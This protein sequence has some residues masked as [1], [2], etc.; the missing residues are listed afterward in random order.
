MK[1]VI[2]EPNS[3]ILKSF[4]SDKHEIRCFEEELDRDLLKRFYSDGK[5]WAFAAQM[6][7][8][9][10]RL[11]TQ[12]RINMF[13]GIA[14]EDRTI[15]E[16]RAIF[17]KTNFEQG[18]MHELEYTVYSQA[19]EQWITRIKPPTLLVYLA[20]NDIQVLLN[21]INKRGRAEEK[22]ISSEYLQGLNNNY[23][24]FY[25]NYPFPK[26]VINASEDMDDSGRFHHEA[27][28]KIAEKLEEMGFRK[29]HIEQQYLF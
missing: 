26:M 25:A 28:K 17:G 10:V 13:N 15:F 8:F 6:Y 3:A 7:F 11:K 23:D 12:D 4:L 27:F 22:S 20:V 24:A 29:K 18:N 21:R 1:E 19:F 5:R 2:R 9:T 14:I 16:D